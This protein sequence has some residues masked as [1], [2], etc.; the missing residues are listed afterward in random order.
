MGALV[1]KLLTESVELALLR[2]GY[3]GLHRALGRLGA[4]RR[5]A[6]RCSGPAY[7][8][9]VVRAGAGGSEPLIAGG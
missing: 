4:G 8:R 7:E 1:I 9:L 6:R 2:R 5:P 3:V